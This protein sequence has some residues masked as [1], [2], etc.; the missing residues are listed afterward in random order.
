MLIQS[1]VVP[2]LAIDFMYVVWHDEWN[3][4]YKLRGCMQM[5]NKH[6]TDAIIESKY[7]A[8]GA[9][10]VIVENTFHD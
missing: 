3:I 4:L 10:L 9:E 1:I 7:Y 6:T 2:H 8:V 5:R